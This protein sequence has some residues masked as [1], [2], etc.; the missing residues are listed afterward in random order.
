MRRFHWFTV[1]F[2]ANILLLMLIVLAV[3]TGLID[4][5]PGQIALLSLMVGVNLLTYIR[6]FTWIRKMRL[7]ERMRPNAVLKVLPTAE[8]PISPWIQLRKKV[9]SVLKGKRLIVIANRE[10]Y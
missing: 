9:Q 8:Q 10:P 7:R 2:F 6:P 5:R 4:S 1:V 3:A